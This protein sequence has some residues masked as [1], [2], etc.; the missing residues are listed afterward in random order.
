LKSPIINTSA[1]SGFKLFIIN[2]SKKHGGWGV[3]LQLQLQLETGAFLP[4]G[5]QKLAV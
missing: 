3:Q 1:N 2:T 5:R 4:T